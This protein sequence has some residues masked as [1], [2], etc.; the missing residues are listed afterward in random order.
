MAVRPIVLW[1]DP[2][3]SDVCAHVTAE[4]D[5]DALDRLI[6]DM[7]ETM[8][9]APGRGLAAPQVAVMQ[10]VFVMD[11]T[12]KEGT[13]SPMAFVN[14]RITVWGDQRITGEEGCLSI[15]GI[16]VP[17]AR[18]DWVAVEWTSPD[19][20]MAA[21]RF[22]GAAA[23]IIQHELDHLDGIVTLDH[24]DAAA[25]AAAEAAYLAL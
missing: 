22:D 15:P 12:W 3:L 13:R 5:A 18:A 16:A 6:S 14:P 2:R 17:V 19:G 9:A 4:Q 8:Y 21:R 10:R 7:F 24:L 23:A 25:R 1:P 11:A 20:E